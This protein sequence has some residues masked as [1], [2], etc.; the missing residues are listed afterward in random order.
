MMPGGGQL[1]HVKR[2]EKKAPK[3]SAQWSAGN[4]L[5]KVIVANLI[6]FDLL[7]LW[8]LSRLAAS[9]QYQSLT[10]LAVVISLPTLALVVVSVLQRDP[11]HSKN[12]SR[13]HLRVIRPPTTSPVAHVHS[14]QSSLSQEEVQD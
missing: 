13:S 8:Y 5:M 3:H 7:M 2:P 10:L 11:R 9:H 6:G 1:G 12:T 14:A 4:L